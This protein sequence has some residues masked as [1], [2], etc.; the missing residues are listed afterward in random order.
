MRSRRASLISVVLLV[1]MFGSTG[2]VC[3]SA[4]QKNPIAG[5]PDVAVGAQY[6]STH[7]YVGPEDFDHF[8]SSVVATFGG[9]TSKQ[10]VTTVTP[11]AS[12][13]LAQFV[14][15]AVGTFSVFAYKTPVPY[16]FGTERTGYLVT[17]MDE[18]VRAARLAGANV[19]VTAF[20]DLIGRDTIIQFP[21]GV[22]TQL[23]VHTTAP[24][25]KVSKRYR[26][27]VCTRP[28]TAPMP[29][30]EAFLL[31]RMARSPPMMSTHLASKSDDRRTHIGEF[32]PNQRLEK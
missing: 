5:S 13:T 19:I 15:T 26:K 21:G 18:A 4:A 11:T 27:I 3:Q 25:Y 24:S 29:L 31:S 2:V 23:Y 10:V 17:D 16:P 8:V 14:L 30:F 20:D 22:N 1:L 32:V 12:S 9:S 6:D 28:S 7:V